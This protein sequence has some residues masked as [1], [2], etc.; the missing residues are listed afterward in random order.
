M[1][2]HDNGEAEETLEFAEVGEDR[3]DI[4]GSVFV[5]AVQANEGVEEEELG[6]KQFD[7]LS[8]SVLVLESIES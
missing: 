1:I 2:N 8:E 4:G 7:G 3:G 6:L 5:D